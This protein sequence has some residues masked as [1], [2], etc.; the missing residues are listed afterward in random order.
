MIKDLQ[1]NW[2]HGLEIMYE[3]VKG[4]A[5]DFNRE[6]NRAER[7]NVIADEQC[8][9]V[10]QQANGPRSARSSSALWDSETCALFIRGRK[11]TSRMK[12][13]PTQQL[14]DSDL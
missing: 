4:Y 5:D 6:L 3:W 7:L 14:L 12:E 11:I 8:D 10:R 1:Q 13:R 2:C 9:L